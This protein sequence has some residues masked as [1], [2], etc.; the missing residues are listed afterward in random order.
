[1][2]DLDKLW[3]KW[4]APH[5]D[6][7]LIDSLNAHEARQT[8][9]DMVG[10]ID[11]LVKLVT[12][13]RAYGQARSALSEAHGKWEAGGKPLSRE[14]STF[15]AYVDART[16]YRAAL[17]RIEALAVQLAG[18]DVRKACEGQVQS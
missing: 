15:G 1:M 17:D 4:S 3:S 6:E 10:D 16:T 8:M 12:E 5:H 11:E 9:R 2:I 13:V 14:F 18:G 7:T